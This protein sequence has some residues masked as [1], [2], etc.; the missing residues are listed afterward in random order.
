MVKI[1]GLLA[2]FILVCCLVEFLKERASKSVSFS[3]K[4]M[5][6]ALARFFEIMWIA[7]FASL[8]LKEILGPP[9]VSILLK[10]N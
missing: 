8:L 3:Q 7:V 6:G 5:C 4:I 1:V 2:A 10:G 9:G